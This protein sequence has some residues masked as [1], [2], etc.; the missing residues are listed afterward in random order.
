MVRLGYA[1]SSEEHT[2]PVLVRD[3]RRAEATGF[4]LVMLSDHFHPWIDRQGHSPF[5]WTVLGGIA[6]TTESV[7]VGT[8]V[9]CPLIRIHPALVAQAALTVAELMPGRFV[10]GLG[11]GENLNEHVTGERW[12]PASIRLDMLEEAIQV[13]RELWT[14]ETVDHHGRYYTVEGAKLY[15]TTEPPRVVVAAKGEDAARLA[16]RCCEGI[17]ATAP[18]PSTIRAFNEA[19][20]SSALRIGQLT[21]CVAE[22]E[23]QARKIAHTQ[24][25]N[26]AITGQLTQELPM[27]SHFEQAA[28]M[29]S[30]DD[31]AEKVIC[32]S[33]VQR[34][35]DGLREYEDA[36]YDHVYV[37]QVGP[38][39]ETFFRFYE[40]EVMPAV[41][42]G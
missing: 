23:Q 10:L 42:A 15:P 32:G 17:V 30:E 13:M 35:I 40:E 28:E 41:A 25:P 1:L 14:G 11:T 20:D 4:E 8:G 18:D 7:T 39:Q 33:D 27:P 21:V 37:H 5:A 19:A 9:T 38:D 22:S 26:A 6:A 2:A 12:P 31:V 24:W 34:H 36:G 16:A 3:A 29:V